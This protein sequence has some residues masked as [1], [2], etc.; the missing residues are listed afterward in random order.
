MELLPI[1]IVLVLLGE[2]LG[3]GAVQAGLGSGAEFAHDDR[4]AHRVLPGVVGD[5]GRRAL[6]PAEIFVVAEDVEVLTERIVER[7]GG[8]F[9]VRDDG[10]GDEPGGIFAARLNGE[11][12]DE[13]VALGAF[14]RLVGHGPQDDGRVVVVAADHFPQLVFGHVER[15]RVGPVDAPVDGNLGPDHDAELVGESIFVFGMRVVGHADEVAVQ[16]PR[17]AKQRLSILL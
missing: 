8:S 13:G 5:G 2:H 14:R 10:G 4:L 3:G 9:E 12:M 7:G 15:V 1:H 17:P 6:V 16:L 11:L